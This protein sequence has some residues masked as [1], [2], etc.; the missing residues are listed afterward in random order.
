MNTEAAF[1]ELPIEDL[2][3]RVSD[4]AVRLEG[5]AHVTPVLTSATLD[6]EIGA[7]VRLKCENL[8]RGGAF[9]F[10][11]AWNAMSRLSAEERSRGVITFSSGNHAQAVALVGSL[12]GVAV[13]VVMPDNSSPLKREATQGYGARVVTC[14]PGE[15]ES[16]AA[17]LQEESG[18]ALIPPFDHSGIIAGQG[19]LAL[20]LHAHSPALDAVLVPVGGGGLLSGVA[21]AMKGLRPACRVI[22]VEPEL[23]DDAAH[24]FH[25][26]TLQVCD[27]CASIADGT[28]T[29]SLGSITF[30]L[31]RRFVDDIVCVSEQSIAQAVR[32]LFHRTKLVVEP[33][34]ALGVAAL[35]SG[36]Y[37]GA[38]NVGVVLSGGNVD[39]SVMADILT[40]AL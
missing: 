2:L 31:I 30:P 26:G 19:T 4:A 11:G 35:L 6:R 18:A 34:G 36:A 40:G 14:A 28:R 37:A 39:A 23:C 8:Q 13:T 21:I 17:A 22:G 16:V 5:H 33:S 3:R 20:E 7:S 9:K 25:S 15:R 12:L 1:A 27:N 10:R 38:G 24:S 32:F 29:R